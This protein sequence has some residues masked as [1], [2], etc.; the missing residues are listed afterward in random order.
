MPSDTIR[1]AA[2]GR[3]I[4]DAA[5]GRANRRLSELQVIRLELDALE[6]SALIGSSAVVH[7]LIR[8][9]AK[10]RDAFAT[11]E[12]YT[13]YREGRNTIRAQLRAGVDVDRWMDRFEEWRDGFRG[14]AAGL[15]TRPKTKPAPRPVEPPAKAGEEE[16]AHG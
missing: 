11:D 12:A 7:R 2:L 8:G 10:P 14:F 9:T 15:V 4:R 3:A 13:R 6:D 16:E 1:D 5:L